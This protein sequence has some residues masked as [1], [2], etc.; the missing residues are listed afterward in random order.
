MSP[1]PST[2]WLARHGLLYVWTCARPTV[3]LGDDT[4]QRAS[5]SDDDCMLLGAPLTPRTTRG[6]RGMAEAAMEPRVHCR[7]S[8]LWRRGRRICC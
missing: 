6:R 2:T 8:G 7:T 5:S 3:A 1:P 4:V